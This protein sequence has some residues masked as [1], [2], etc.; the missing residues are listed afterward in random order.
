[1]YATMRRLCFWP[2][3]A[4]DVDLIVQGC[5]PCAKERVTLRKHASTLNLFPANAP[6]ESVAIDLLGPLPVTSQ[7]N[8]YLL[9]MTD[10]FTKL[11]RTVPL[12]SISAFKVAKAFWDV[13]V[14]A[15][16]APATLL[17]DNGGQFVSKFFQSV[18]KA[19]S[20][21]N[22]FTTA[23]HPQTNGQVER[24]NRTLKSALRRLVAKNQKDWDFYSDALTYGYNI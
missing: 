9:A 13:C 14:Y 4:L 3:M 12:K 20:I 8:R 16:E 24:Y 21:H 10:R 18:C 17:S 2:R 6:L 19:L 15:Y 23:Y 7:G 11:T 1:M 22:A 5:N